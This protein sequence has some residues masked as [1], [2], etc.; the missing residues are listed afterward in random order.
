[1]VY[2]T[3]GA[4]LETV[5]R[6]SRDADGRNKHVRSRE[7]RHELA[8]EVAEMPHRH[9]H[10][11]QIEGLREEAQ[12]QIRDRQ[13]DDK[14]VARSAH[15]WVLSDDVTHE[16]IS[17]GAEDDEQSKGDDQHHLS[18]SREVAHWNHALVVFTQQPLYL[19]PAHERVVE[20][21]P[22]HVVVLVV[23]RVITAPPV[24]GVRQPGRVASQRHLA[25]MPCRHC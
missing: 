2:V 8:H 10:L 15:V 4:H 3:A 13:I 23:V 12:R 18:A 17:G 21:Q 11:H 5:Q 14:Y 19:L 1:M 7:H 6:Y 22:F 24:G 20:R 25:N 9:R 16:A